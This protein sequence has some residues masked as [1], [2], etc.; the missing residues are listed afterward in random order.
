M[1]KYVSAL[2][3]LLSSMSSRECP[4]LTPHTSALSAA[5]MLPTS[6]KQLHSKV[7]PLSDWQKNYTVSFFSWTEEADTDVK[8]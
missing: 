4:T 1:Y 5:R 2:S 3:A 6:K 8:I 7:T